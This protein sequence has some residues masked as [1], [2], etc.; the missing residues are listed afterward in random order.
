MDKGMVDI[1]EYNKQM[2]QH[3]HLFEFL[4]LLLLV[5]VF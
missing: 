2:D 4:N 5:L 1:K 3:N